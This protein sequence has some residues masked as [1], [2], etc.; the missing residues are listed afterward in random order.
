VTDARIE[1]S[2]TELYLAVMERDAGR[3]TEA[4]AHALAAVQRSADRPLGRAQTKAWSARIEL[5]RGDARGG[6]E[7]AL[8]AMADLREH[9]IDDSEAVVHLAL[10]EALEAAGRGDEAASAAERGVAVLEDCAGRISDPAWRR[11]FLEAVPEHAALRSI[12]ARLG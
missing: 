3:L 8:A 12:A 4:S 1:L 9:G 6:L 11:S 10:A 7:L 2:V 5:A